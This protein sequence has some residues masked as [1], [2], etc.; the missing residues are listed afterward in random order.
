MAGRAK[1]EVCPWSAVHSQTQGKIGRWYQTMGNC[2]PL[3]YCYLPCHLGRQIGAFAHY[4][5]YQCHHESLDNVTRADLFFD[6]DKAI[7]RESEEFKEL[8]IRRRRTQYQKN[9]IITQTSKSLQ[10]SNRSRVPNCVTSD[11]HPETAIPP[12]NEELYGE[13]SGRR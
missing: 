10:W 4:C 13:N 1:H 9:G 2:V 5:N 12:P 11:S 8:A 6:R 7:L 3:E